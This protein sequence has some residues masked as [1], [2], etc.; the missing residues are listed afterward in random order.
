MKRDD[1]T[2]FEEITLAMLKATAVFMF[3]I[4]LGKLVTL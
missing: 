4:L 3:V 1:K 2:R